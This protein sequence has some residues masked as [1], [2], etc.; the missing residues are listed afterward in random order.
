MAKRKGKVGE[1]ATNL[2]IPDHIWAR[3]KDVS[4]REGRS[5][6]SEIN[7][8]VIE[9]LN[10]RGYKLDMVE[11]LTDDLDSGVLDEDPEDSA[12]KTNTEIA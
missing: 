12:P 8:A 4:A 11:D 9:Y 7:A 5:L 10:K 1:T 2:R 6:N 3:L